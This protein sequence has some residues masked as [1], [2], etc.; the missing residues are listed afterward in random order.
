MNDQLIISG[1]PATQITEG[2]AYSFVPQVQNP[3][4]LPLVF[5][6]VNAPDWIDFNTQTGAITGV[7]GLADIGVTRNISIRVS[8]GSELVSLAPFD[9]EVAASATGSVELSW[10]APTYN[11]DGSLVTSNDLV[12]YKV[13]YGTSAGNYPNTKT[14][15]NPGIVNSLVENL[16][17]G[18]WYF[19]LTAYNSDGQ[20]SAYS[21]VL[22]RTVP[23]S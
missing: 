20:E 21:G 16:T 10:N 15:S 23:N 3:D 22:V 7:P 2:L 4:G 14:I 12:G 17:P 19:V 8:A 5:S 6:I 18:T 11:T 13:Y 9:L 1:S